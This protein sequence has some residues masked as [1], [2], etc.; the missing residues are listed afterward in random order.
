MN[1]VAIITARGGSKRIPRKNIKDFLGRP[2][3]AY[4][5]AAALQSGL[6]DEVMVST[7]DEEIAEVANAH[8]AKVPFMRSAS[9]ADDHAT[10]V[11]VLVEVLRS[12][13]AMGHNF[14]LGCCIYPT[15][16]FVTP[17]KLAAGW[18]MLNA[19]GFD[20]VFPVVRF[21]FPIQRAL[22]LTDGRLSMID[23]AHLTTRS[24]DLEPAFHDVGQFYWFRSEPLL[25]SRS[26]LGGN[27][28]ALVVDELEVQDID[29]LVDWKLAE[30]KYTMRKVNQ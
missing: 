5:I 6:F 30:L 12:Y 22:R 9:N 29:T 13:A 28:G 24:Q 1:S 23:P 21:G 16:P 18:Q 26:L 3:M 25:E 17:E 10:T 14:A 27:T 20:C 15:A 4:S 2:I 19:Q 7:D 11:D 8:G